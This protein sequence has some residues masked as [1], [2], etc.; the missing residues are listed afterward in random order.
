MLICGLSDGDEGAESFAIGEIQY[1]LGTRF[2]GNQLNDVSASAGGG[3]HPQF[4]CFCAGINHLQDTEDEFAAF[5]LSRSWCD[6]ERVVLILQPE[7]GASRVFRPDG[8]AQP[9]PVGSNTVQ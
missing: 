8:T 7:E 2:G 6:A 4:S 9:F 1:W 3:K 5:V